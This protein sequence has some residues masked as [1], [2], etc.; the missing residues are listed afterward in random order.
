[1]GKHYGMCLK[2]NLT[3]FATTIIGTTRLEPANSSLLSVDQQQ[4][5]YRF[6]RMIC[7]QLKELSLVSDDTLQTVTR[8]I[9]S[10]SSKV[11]L[12]TCNGCRVVDSFHFSELP[13]RC[14]LKP[15]CRIYRGCGSI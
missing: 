8:G 10:T 15:G 13:W 7:Q 9:E 1:M 12:R 3:S 14:F 5:S 4:K 6:R 2:L 11:G